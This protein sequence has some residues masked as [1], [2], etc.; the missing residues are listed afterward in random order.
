MPNWRG[1]LVVAP[2]IM[3]ACSVGTDFNVERLAWALRPLNITA[4]VSPAASKVGSLSTRSQRNDG[5][6]RQQ[7]TRTATVSDA[8]PSSVQRATSG[9]AL[10]RP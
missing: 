4:F 8:R 10:G 7:S 3:L 1:Q 2:G 9:S 5:S 6:S